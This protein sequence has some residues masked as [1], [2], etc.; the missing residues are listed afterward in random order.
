MT[1]TQKIRRAMLGSKD[2]RLLL[3]RDRN[4][5][6]ASAA[7][8]SPL[9]QEPDAVIISKSRSV[10]EEV[11][12]VLATSPEWSKSYQVKRNLIENPKT[13]TMLATRFVSHMREHDL[14][15]LAKSKNVTA[16]VQDAARRHLQRRST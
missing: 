2:E 11:L 16:P 1:V 9:L 8:R 12:R 15:S 7:V 14:K 3:V 13:P 6:V 5:I 4:K 10:S